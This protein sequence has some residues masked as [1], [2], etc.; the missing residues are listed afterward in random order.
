M[1]MVTCHNCGRRFNKA[2]T[3][4]WKKVYFCSLKCLVDYY[5]SH[6]C[7]TCGELITKYMNTVKTHEKM[8]CS[9]GCEAMYVLDSIAQK[10]YS[11]TIC[12][13]VAKNERNQVQG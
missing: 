2:D 8:F 11:A 9:D 7:E 3:I 1:R 12:K 13:E 4:S 5:K 10:L 6:H